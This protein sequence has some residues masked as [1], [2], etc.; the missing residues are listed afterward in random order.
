MTIACARCVA[1][2]DH[3][4]PLN[5]L[6][7]DHKPIVYVMAIAAPNHNTVFS[8]RY[9]DCPFLGQTSQNKVKFYPG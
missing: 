4:M 1:F 5:V 9:C 6:F 7:W 2:S 8:T 3:S